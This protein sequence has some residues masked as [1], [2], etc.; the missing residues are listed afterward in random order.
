MSS[1]A[2][3]RTWLPIF[4]IAGY[5]LVC[6]L[7]VGVSGDF[8]L[9]DDWSYA[10]GVRHYMQW[11]EFKMPTVCAPG[12]PH[13]LSGAFVAGLF[14]YSYVTFRCLSLLLGLAGTLFLFFSLRELGSRSRDAC[15]LS[16]LYA[17]NPIMV[18]MHFGFMSDV[19]ALN[20]SNIY[21]FLAIKALKR[22]RLT[23]FLAALIMLLIVISVRQ[24]C[25][26]LVV[27]LLPWLIAG[28]RRLIRGIVWL[29]LMLLPCIL[30]YTAVDHWLLTRDSN[31]QDYILARAGHASLI[32]NFLSQPIEQT[33]RLI[34]ALGMVACYFGLFLAP[35]LPAFICPPRLLLQLL[36]K[37]GSFLSGKKRLMEN[38]QS[39]PA[40]GL[41]VAYGLA[42]FVSLK[43]FICVYLLSRMTMPFMENIFRVT[44]VGASGII[45]VAIPALKQRGRERLT[46]LSYLL[47]FLALSTILQIV[48]TVFL[49]FWRFASAHWRDKTQA[50]PSLVLGL[51]AALLTG[52]ALAAC[53]VETVVRC[54]DRYY[55]IALVPALMCLALSGRWRRIKIATVLPVVLMIAGCLYSVCA[56]QDYLSWNRARWALIQM[57]ERQGVSREDLDGGAEYNIVRGLEIYSSSYRGEP[58]R[59]DWRWWPVRG[60]KYIVSF[61]TIPNYDVVAKESYWSALEWRNG[62]VLLL[63]R[64]D[65]R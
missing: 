34:D 24:S 28:E 59:S 36:A 8:P 49:K 27:F 17:A 30:V 54:T 46:L 45:G 21:F 3:R 63:R 61:S 25:I 31:V 33:G 4:L 40:L 15:F 9:N 6:L 23:Y 5:F 14:G 51:A 58:P 2:V 1:E 44:T 42:L 64:V 60:E 62:E 12:F 29:L 37:R 52:C 35:A 43:S 50:P 48:L 18:N 41:A 53:A 11:H 56:A 16:L 19:T 38:L 20:L 22:K 65:A 47:G 7:F 55:M 39:V 32:R 10:E 57:I 26:L 13:V